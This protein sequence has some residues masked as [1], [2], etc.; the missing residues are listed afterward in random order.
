MYRRRRYKY[1]RKKKLFR[2]KLR[3]YYSKRRKFKRRWG[4]LTR[5]RGIRKPISKVGKLSKAVK[6]LQVRASDSVTRY[7]LREYSTEAVTV[8][9]NQVEWTQ[10]SI[11]SKSQFNIT[12]GNLPFFDTGDVTAPV[13]MNLEVPSSG[14]YMNKKIR[15]IFSSMKTTWVNNDVGPIYIT[16]YF[17]ICKTDTSI[18]PITA[19]TNSYESNSVLFTGMDINSFS[20]NPS[21]CQ[22]LKDLYIIK[23]G[24]TKLLQPGHQCSCYMKVPAVQWDPSIGFDQDYE[25]RKALKTSHLLYKIRG[26]LA[27]GTTPTNVGTTSLQ[28][29]VL[30]ERHFVVEYDGGV[31]MNVYNEL[32]I[33]DNMTNEN[34]VNKPP[35]QI[36]TQ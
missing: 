21:D 16:W 14:G 17:V 13:Y 36:I 1:S 34:F 29:D 23:K 30:V 10:H 27:H 4:F 5:K 15:Q 9:S 18:A 22:L 6:N 24:K 35:T 2:R 28:L 12:M 33:L 26:G 3:K 31:T 7:F 20:S 19:M 25:Y 32:N 11:N 8:N